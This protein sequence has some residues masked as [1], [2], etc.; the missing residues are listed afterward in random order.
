MSGLARAR[1]VTNRSLHATD[2]TPEVYWR[3]GRAKG[4][5]GVETCEREIETE[6]ET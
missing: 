5:L 1:Y 3:R 6:T 2:L 4:H